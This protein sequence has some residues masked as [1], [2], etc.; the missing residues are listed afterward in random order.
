MFSAAFNHVKDNITELNGRAGA[1]ETDLIFLK[2]L[3]DSSVLKSLVKVSIYIIV[4]EILKQLNLIVL[5]WLY[6]NLISFD[7]GQLGHTVRRYTILMSRP[8][9]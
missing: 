9:Y 1:N 2:G 5:N 8:T 3:M 6:D 4:Y 7:K